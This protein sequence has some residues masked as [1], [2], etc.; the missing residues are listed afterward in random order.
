MKTEIKQW[1]IAVGCGVLI[2]LIAA[3]GFY[4][5]PQYKVY[6]ARLDGEAILARAEASKRAQVYDAE[7]KLESAKY[8][9]Q[10]AKEIQ[11][12]LTPAYLKYLEIQMQENVGE[13]NPNTVYF[14]KGDE[15]PNVINRGE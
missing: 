6:L 11:S 3:G 13:H 1:A 2:L 12:S 15:V 7:A 9:K 5:F 14:Y 10:A 8:L 4:I